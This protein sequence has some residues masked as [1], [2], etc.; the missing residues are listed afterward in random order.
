MEDIYL[1]RFGLAL[2]GGS[3][4]QLVLIFTTSRFILFVNVA[5]VQQSKFLFF[6]MFFS[7]MNERTVTRQLNVSG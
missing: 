5:I 6:L 7:D 1:R 4:E 2:L 3:L